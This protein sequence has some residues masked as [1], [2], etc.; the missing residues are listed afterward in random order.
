MADDSRLIAR[1]VRSLSPLGLKAIDGM[2][3]VLEKLELAPVDP[4]VAAALAAIKA[5]CEVRKRFKQKGT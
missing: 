4:R 3:D 5:G 1:Y 2:C